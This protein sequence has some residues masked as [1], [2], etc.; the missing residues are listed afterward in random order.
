M[1]VPVII[2]F[3]FDSST[4]GNSSPPDSL[5]WRTITE[6]YLGDYITEWWE[7]RKRINREL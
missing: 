1:Y 3:F 7:L 4:G 2:I 6:L 5:H